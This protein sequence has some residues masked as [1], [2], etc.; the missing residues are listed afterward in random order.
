MGDENNSLVFLSDRYAWSLSDDDLIVAVSHLNEPE[1]NNERLLRIDNL[2]DE[3]ISKNKHLTL[4]RNDDGFLLRFLRA[5]KFHHSKALN[6]LT[7]YHTRLPAWPAVFERITNPLLIKH[8]YDAGCY[9]ALKGKAKDGS[10]V[11]IGRPGRIEN[12]QFEEFVAAVLLSYERLLEDEKVQIYGIAAIEDL[13]FFGFQMVKQLLTFK[14]IKRMIG[15]LQ[16][17]M[18]IRIRSLNVVFESALCD[19]LYYAF[20]APFMKEKLKKRV[21]FYGKNVKALSKIVDLSFLP[22][23]YGGTNNDSVDGDVAV[24]WKNIVFAKR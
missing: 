4:I 24:R 14:Q 2:R 12:P 8:V 20:V 22:P 3:F 5:K 15:M 9:V 10:T 23:A 19:L 13:T 21:Q 6:M 7:N 18:P 1:D 17:C 16:D 11:C